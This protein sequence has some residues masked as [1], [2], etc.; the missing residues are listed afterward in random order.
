MDKKKKQNSTAVEET[1]KR[2]QRIR[3]EGEARKEATRLGVSYVNIAG[4]PIN[5]ETISMI[6]EEKAIQY[7]AVPYLEVADTV[8]VATTD[9]QNEKLINYL[10]TLKKEYKKDFKPVMASK[11][12]IK[13]GLGLYKKIEKPTGRKVGEIT[14]SKEKVAEEISDMGNLKEKLQSASTTE[15]LDILL[16]GAIGL[17]SSDIHIV[18]ARDKIRIRF[19]IDGVLHDVAE[20]GKEQYKKLDS[21]IKFLAKMKMGEDYLPQDGRF[22]SK[23]AGRNID[24]RV[25]TLPT[26]HGDSIVARLLEE[27]QKGIAL[28]ELGFNE[29]ALK[30]IQGAIEKPNGMILNTGPTGSGKTTTLYAIIN[31]L[32]KPEVKIV[33]LEDPVEYQIEGIDQT[34]IDPRHDLNFA[35]GLRAALRQDPDIIMVGEIRDFETASISLHASLTGHLLL[36]TL[37]TNNA[38]AAFVRLLDMRIRPFLLVGSINLAIAQRLVRLICPE[39]KE[40]YKPKKN[41]KIALESYLKKNKIKKMPPLYHGKG[42]SICNKTGY[43]GRTAII[44]FIEPNEEI[45]KL[46]M[47][48]ATQSEIEMRAIKSG[49]KTMLEDGF[50]KVLAGQTTI[51]EVLRVTT[52]EE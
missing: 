26:L 39:C 24:L 40:E 51:E 46:I 47:Q 19:R 18:P 8:R 29:E 30:A 12:G 49:M 36:T 21:R 32:N 9:P 5:S 50:D 28:E 27:N 43:S 11:T 13:F 10:T 52:I 31:K 42:C 2:A 25:S 33:T 45:E 44:E 20:I 3:E 16:A 48:E 6:P 14:I 1:I 7:N 34:Q 37:H 17:R 15:L 4:F 22:S 41:E 23:I 35:K 38:P